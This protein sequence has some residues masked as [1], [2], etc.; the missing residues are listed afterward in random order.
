MADAVMSGAMEEVVCPLEHKFVNG[1][2]ERTVTMFRGMVVVSK[3]HKT[4]H[5]YVISEGVVA[6]KVNDGGWNLLKAPYH[7]ET[8]AGTRRV[9]YIVENTRWTTYHRLK[10]GETT[11]EQVEK[12]IIKKHKHPF[13]EMKNNYS[14]ITDNK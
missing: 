1:W 10:D 12:R 5:E 14:Q 6:V 13:I 8:K 2:Y 4:N 7:G 9:L 3:I 11:P